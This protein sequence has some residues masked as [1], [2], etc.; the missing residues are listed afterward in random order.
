MQPD[1]G[2]ALVLDA[3]QDLDDPVMER[4]AADDADCRVVPYLPEQMFAAA[5]ADL[6]PDVGC[7]RCEELTEA[8]RHR[9]RQVERDARQRILPQ[10]GL[11]SA[12]R[13]PAPAAVAA[14]VVLVILAHG[15]VSSLRAT[16][17]A[18]KL[19]RAAP[20]THLLRCVRGSLAGWRRKL[21]FKACFSVTGR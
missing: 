9:L 20:D 11:P 4:L 14:Q 2:E 19:P 5:E 8:R 16:P 10:C 13:A 6:Q 12:R 21:S 17:V 3:A 1:I 7:G 18:R 15:G